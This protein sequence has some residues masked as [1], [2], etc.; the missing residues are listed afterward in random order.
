[1]ALFYQVSAPAG[2]VFLWILLGFSQDGVFH[3]FN[4]ISALST[5]RMAA[6]LLTDRP[7]SDSSAAAYPVIA[8]MHGSPVKL[9]AA[10]STITGRARCRMPVTG[11]GHDAHLD[12][13]DRWWRRG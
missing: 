6:Q 8:W 9:R 11:G 12:V 13:L 1:M 3:S 7:E 4:M 2:S 5:S 10:R